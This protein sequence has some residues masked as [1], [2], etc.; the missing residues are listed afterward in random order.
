MCAISNPYISFRVSYAKVFLLAMKL[1]KIT[2]Q[3]KPS[4]RSKTSF[5]YPQLKHTLLLF[6]TSSV[7]FICNTYSVHIVR[8]DFAFKNSL[9]NLKEVV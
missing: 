4:T 3:Y 5:F 2:F 6:S 8:N 7:K 1:A 9:K